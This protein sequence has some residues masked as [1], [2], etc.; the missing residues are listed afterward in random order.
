MVAE[1][2]RHE[3]LPEDENT[4]SKASNSGRERQS[5]LEARETYHEMGKPWRARG[6]VMADVDICTVAELMG[7]KKIQMPPVPVME[8]E[9]KSPRPVSRLCKADR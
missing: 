1:I 2:E 3:F 7:H 6:E 4:G 8:P 5:D 9:R